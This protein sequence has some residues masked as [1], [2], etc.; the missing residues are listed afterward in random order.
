MKIQ[1]TAIIE[2]NSD[3]KYSC[4]IEQRLGNYGIAG[5]GDTVDEAKSDMLECYDEMK[6]INAERNIETPELDFLYK[7]DIQSFF[8]YFNFFNVTKIAEKAGI[9]PSLLRQY[10]SGAAFAS[11][12]QYQKL[13]LAIDT[14]KSDLQLAVF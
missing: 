6:E 14:I 3:G 10:A 2:K 4:S 12:K 1:V 13:R 5:Y 9:N 8:N 11:E 7:Y